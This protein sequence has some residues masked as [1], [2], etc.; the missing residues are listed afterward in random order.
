MKTILTILLFVQI[1]FAQSKIMISGTDAE[2]DSIVYESLKIAYPNAVVSRSLNT[3]NQPFIDSIEALGYNMLVR[4]TTGYEA[5]KILS[6]T[7]NVLFVMPSGSNNHESTGI[8]LGSIVSTGCGTDSNITG[9][10]IHYFAQDPT[11][12][13]LSS[14]SNGYIA[15]LIAEL[16]DELKITPNEVIFWAKFG[17]TPGHDGYGKFDANYVRTYYEKYHRKIYI[18]NKQ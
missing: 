17:K 5:Y 11:G 8:T 2:H 3:L 13:N 14:Y 15:G 16:S 9:Y 4:S 12:Q 18:K 10:P 1:G 7:N 6:D